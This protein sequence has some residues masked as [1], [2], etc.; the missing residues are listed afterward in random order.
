M[1]KE[2][3]GF[4][5]LA[6]LCSCNGKRADK[7]SSR[8]MMHLTDTAFQ[9]LLDTTPVKDIIRPLEADEL[10][11]DF[12]FNYALDASLQRQRTQFP[13]SY[14]CGDTVKNIEKKDWIHDYLFAK[15]NY[16][17]LLFDNEED[18]DLVED[19]SLH[20]VQVEWISL[21]KPEVKIYYFVRMQSMWMLEKINVMTDE[22]GKD[23]FISF[24]T[25]FATDS[26]FQRSHIRNP[27]QFITIDPDD[28]FSVLET[29]LDIDQWYAFRPQLPTVT[30][31]NINYGQR[32]RKNSR[33]KILKINGIGNGYSNTFYFNRRN[34]K[35]ELYKYE[36]TSI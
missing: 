30:I 14:Q 21:V 16:Y 7:V 4:L 26:V 31:S 5:L 33:T 20:A 11:D 29:T 10:F 18:M 24:Y 1:R 6:V 22:R 13:L 15:Q 17:T 23:D 27:M 8:D 35:W 9:L 2:L 19:T 12:I 25:R 36:D 32:N 34:G 28:D 3:T